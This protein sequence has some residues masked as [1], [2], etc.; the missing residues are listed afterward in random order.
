MWLVTKERI[1]LHAWWWDRRTNGETEWGTDWSR[2]DQLHSD[3]RLFSPAQKQWPALA[4]GAR[5][6][7]EGGLMKY[8]LQ[9][10]IDS[11]YWTVAC[12]SWYFTS[13]CCSSRTGGQLSWRLFWLFNAATQNN[14][15]VL[16]PNQFTSFFNQNLSLQSSHNICKFSCPDEYHV[17]NIS[18]EFERGKKHFAQNTAFCM[19]YICKMYRVHRMP[20]SWGNLGD[21]TWC[22]HFHR[23]EWK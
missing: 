3:I 12:S 2:K 11:C 4:G 1:K 19:K 21:K 15:A 14:C 13:S 16:Y 10:F 20:Q 8:C 22:F 17:L 9:H 5:Q 18:S 6:Y 23:Q 7:L